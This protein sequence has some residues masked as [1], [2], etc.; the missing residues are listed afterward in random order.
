MLFHKSILSQISQYMIGAPVIWFMYISVV[1][2]CSVVMHKFSRDSA[3]K[4]LNFIRITGL[5]SN[6]FTAS[7]V[8]RCVPDQVC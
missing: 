3:D 8:T 6:V 2:L 1:S 5:I 7:H 4:F